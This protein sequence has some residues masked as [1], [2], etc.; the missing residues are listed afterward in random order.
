MQQIHANDSNFVTAVERNSAAG[1]CSQQAALSSGEYWA[2]I[3]PLI[4][5]PQKT[6]CRIFPVRV[7]PFDELFCRNTFGAR[8]WWTDSSRIFAFM[9]SSLGQRPFYEKSIKTKGKRRK[10]DDVLELK[11]RFL[12]SCTSWWK[13]FHWQ[14]P[15]NTSL[16]LQRRLSKVYPNHP[17]IYYHHKNNSGGSCSVW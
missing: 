4:G 1:V 5:S 3:F 8:F 13:P 7:Y 10:V 14:H 12:H 6:T 17:P 2:S 11:K 9:F 15:A 16:S